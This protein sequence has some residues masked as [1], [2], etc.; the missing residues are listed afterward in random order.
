MEAVPQRPCILLYEDQ[1]AFCRGI[2]GAG[3][4]PVAVV[5]L[6]EN[7]KPGPEGT[8]CCR[9]LM[10]KAREQ[11]G[12]EAL[13]CAAIFAGDLILEPYGAIPFAAGVAHF[14]ELAA[15]C[16]AAGAHWVMVYCARSLLQARA[17]VLG[18]RAAGLPVLVSMEPLGEGEVLLGQTDLLSAFAVLQELG[19]AAFGYSTS[20]TGAQLEA[21]ETIRPHRRIPV[22]SVTRN[23]TGNLSAE[24]TNILFAQRARQLSALGVGMMGIR[25]AKE[26]QLVYAAG[27]LREARLADQEEESELE[28]D[29]I[30]AANETQ[31]YYLDE[32]LE[33]SDP[34][35]CRLDMTDDVLEA[36]RSGC[37]VLCIQ[38]DS[39]DDAY[40]ISLNNGH[41][42]Q[43]PVAFL[44][45]S[46]EALEAA[47]FYYNGRA[48]I[49]SRSG[50]EPEV[51]EELADRYGA[52]VL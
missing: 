5:P 45:E 32:N 28:P 22:F 15:A 37:D 36:E 2:A 43:L 52:V 6:P 49:D 27:A 9:R 42:D 3:A 8:A 34:V 26:E 39:A 38:L 33:F 12:G 30:W 23:L 46:E 50:L 19:I 7:L 47:L 17:G 14:H 44:G 1:L 48:I 24:D 31:V 20:F 35:E 51:L 10:E 21:L 11:T 25:G 16:A 4:Q 40:A 41:I 29:N 18:C 13:L